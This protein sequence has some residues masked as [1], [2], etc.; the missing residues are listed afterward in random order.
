MD[1]LL[2]DAPT[3][4]EVM[5]AVRLLNQ[6]RLL[7]SGDIAAPMYQ[8]RY[9]MTR[10]QARRELEQAVAEGLLIDVGLLIDPVTGRQVRAYRR[11]E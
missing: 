9:G 5:D 1:R 4:D 7:Q 10:A 2:A 3:E 6:S 8:E 11:A